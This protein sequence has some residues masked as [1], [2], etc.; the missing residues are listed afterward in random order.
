[1]D[2]HFHVLDRGSYWILVRRKGHEPGIAEVAVDADDGLITW[3]HLELALQLDETITA[4]IA[5]ILL[6]SLFVSISSSRRRVDRFSA[7]SPH[8]AQLANALES[9]IQRALRIDGLDRPRARSALRVCGRIAASTAAAGEPPRPSGG[10]A[11]A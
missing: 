2:E 8:E 5:E 11:T 7:G 9:A 1:M 4:P 6:R 10:I 3:L